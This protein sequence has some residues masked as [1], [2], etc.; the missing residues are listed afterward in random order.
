MNKLFNTRKSILFTLAAVLLS[1][2]FYTYFSYNKITPAYY[3]Y[4]PINARIQ[5]MDNYVKS[6][7]GYLAQSME[8][9]AYTALESI[10]EERSST[11]I[12]FA[13]KIE[14]DNMFAECVKCGIDCATVPDECSHMT[15]TDIEGFIRNMTEIAKNRLNLKTIYEVNSVQVK[16]S[17]PFEVEVSLNITY[18]VTDLSRSFLSDNFASWNST[19]IITRSVSIIG[20]KDPLLGISTAKG[21]E[22]DINLSSICAYNE[23]CWNI[24]S[25][26]LFYDSNSYHFSVEG[27]GYIQRFWN[28]SS[29]SPCCGIESFLNIGE[30]SGNNSYVDHYYYTGNY[31][32]S[33]IGGNKV[34]IIQFDNIDTGFKLDEETA[35]RYNILDDGELICQYP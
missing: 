15:A 29:N 35:V 1:A 20:L 8:I 25:A 6:F 26:K 2:L 18:Y 13:D 5:V 30:A 32:C 4:Q 21:Y 14:F 19:K 11:G 28:D 34:K 9:S 12:F 27:T 23:S 24:T 33:P 3:I 7:D 16:Q 31:T 17:W 10:Y 22:R